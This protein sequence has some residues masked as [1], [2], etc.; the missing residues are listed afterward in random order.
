VEL[1][2]NEELRQTARAE[3]DEARGP[4]YE[5]KSLLGD[6]DPPLDYRK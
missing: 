2:T 6:R 4:D 3:F 5:Y 1:F